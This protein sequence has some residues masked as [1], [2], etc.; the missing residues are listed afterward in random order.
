MV[1]RS[2][3]HSGGLGERGPLP[4]SD[5]GSGYRQVTPGSRT[6]TLALHRLSPT[7]SLFSLRNSGSLE[8]SRR[9]PG[10]APKGASVTGGT[11]GPA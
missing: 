2:G 5:P 4:L 3:H 7:R 11:G 6:P 1:P 10:L 9:M 8:N